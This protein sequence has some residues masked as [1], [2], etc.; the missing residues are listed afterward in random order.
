MITL[1]TRRGCQ[2]FQCMF[3]KHDD[4]GLPDMMTGNGS[5]LCRKWGV[6]LPACTHRH[7]DTTGLVL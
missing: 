1:T 7:S 5:N 3:C 2:K 6:S 4:V